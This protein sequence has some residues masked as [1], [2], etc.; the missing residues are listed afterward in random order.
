MNG[1]RE[2]AQFAAD[3]LAIV[4]SHY[5][6][7]TISEI[8]PFK[9]GS[10]KSPKIMIRSSRGS[11][12]LKRRAP[13]REDPLKVAFCHTV[14]THLARQGFPLPR[15][16]PTKR[17]RNSMVRY[18]EWTYEMF[19][20]VPGEPYDHSVPETE[21]SGRTLGGYHKYLAD[22][23]SD[24]E[25]PIGG[26][27]NN[28]SVRNSLNH[29][30]TRLKGHDSVYGREGELV[31]TTQWLFEAYE[32]AADEGEAAGF[33]R[34]PSQVV[35]GDWH[36]GNLLY[37]DER[38]VAVIDYDSARV[39]PRI[40]DIANGVLQFSILAGE[41]EPEEW[42]D[43]F[44]EDRAVAFLR[45]YLQNLA[46]EP[47]QLKLIPALMQE[48][49]IAE[50]ALPIATTGSFGRIQGFG[51]LKMVKRKIQW[52]TD[53]KEFWISLFEKIQPEPETTA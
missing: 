46:I 16:I 5:D 23:Q 48:A 17:H 11:F 51:I 47:A 30:P 19:Q 26:Y 40:M 20:Y 33:S 36:P 31:A 27:H 10:R 22:Y 53:R 35:H 45:G 34:W 1:D 42:P 3:E 25:P 21:D 8:T 14:Q 50:S 29:V 44:D 2:R 32:T 4:L 41:G 9:R 7:G 39:Q 38:V 6:L 13:G 49:L 52:L 37:K 28:D 18:R 24:Y 12:V 43:H 15:L